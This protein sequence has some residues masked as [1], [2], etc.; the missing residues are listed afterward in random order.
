MKTVG[1]FKIIAERQRSGMARVRI[2]PH[3][4]LRRSMSCLCELTRYLPKGGITELLL[5]V[6]FT[7]NAS[8][9]LRGIVSKH[10]T[11]FVFYNNNGVARARLTCH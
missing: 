5:D 1:N 3:K 10:I 2:E 9:N 4:G 7:P 8:C 11:W 6:V